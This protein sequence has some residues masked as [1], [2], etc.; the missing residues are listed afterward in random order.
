VWRFDVTALVQRWVTTPSANL[1]LVLVQNPET[2]ANGGRFARFDSR[3]G[4]NRPFLEIV[5]GN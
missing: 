4:A 1:G 2:V 3:E 5:V